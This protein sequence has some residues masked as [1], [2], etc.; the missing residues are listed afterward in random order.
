MA[1]MREIKLRIDSVKKTKQITKAMKLISVSKMKKA[2]RQYEDTLP[3]Y[4]KVKEVMA[5]ILNNEENIDN[6]FFEKKRNRKKR[7]DKKDSNKHK[8]NK[9]RVYF[10]LSGDKGL[11]GGYNNNIVK[12]VQN[13]VEKEDRLYVA[14]Y[15]GRS[16]FIKNG[17]NVDMEF[18]YP[19][20]NPT[21][22]RAGDI[23]DLF[24]TKFKQNELDEFY[25]V[26]TKMVSGMVFEANT[27][28]L[29]PFDLDE[30]IKEIGGLKEEKSE[31]RYE[32]S[33]NEVFRVL[34]EKYIKGILYGLMVEAFVSEQTSR[35]TAMDSATRNA[36][37]MIKDLNL[38]YNRARQAHITQEIT[39]II[40]GVNGL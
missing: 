29:L 20:Q 3:F 2:R 25:V 39:E 36:D 21:L 14:G 10:V 13:S 15:F 32:P 28:K 12:E 33:P 30:L 38:Y 18:D 35:M 6:I 34:L 16:Y 11:A 8:A 24:L 17:F 40:G 27:I 26:Y 7:D 19:V 31:L 5:D 37:K 22:L 9:R 23:A 1:K 4:N